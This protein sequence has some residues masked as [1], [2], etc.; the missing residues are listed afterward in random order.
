MVGVKLPFPYWERIL[1]GSRPAAWLAVVTAFEC[2]W[3]I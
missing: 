2:N 1:T 3:S